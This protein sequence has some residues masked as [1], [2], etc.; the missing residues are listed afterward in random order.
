MK[1]LEDIRRELLDEL[2]QT[3][4]KY[5]A[6]IDKIHK[7]KDALLERA[8][9]THEDVSSSLFIDGETHRSYL[10]EVVFN[11]PDRELR[12]EIMEKINEEYYEQWDHWNARY[13]TELAFVEKLRDDRCKLPELKISQIRLA[14]LPL[15]ASPICLTAPWSRLSQ[16]PP[17]SFCSFLRSPFLWLSGSTN[18]I[19][20][21]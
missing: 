5:K 12:R 13:Y 3:S 8:G 4:D 15:Y 1:S 2:Q 14:A 18:Y 7:E 11:V 17:L 9:I 10:R 6:Q 21:M 20:M 19:G 16:A